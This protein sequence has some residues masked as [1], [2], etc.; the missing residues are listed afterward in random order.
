MC[1]PWWFLAACKILFVFVATGILCQPLHA[2]EKSEKVQEGY[3]ASLET[4]AGE[5]RDKYQ[6]GHASIQLLLQLAEVYLDMG[7]DLYAHNSDRLRAY[8]EGAEFA[9]EALAHDQQNADAHFLYAANLGHVAQL[10]G[11]IEAALSINEIMSHV[12]TAVSLDSSHAGALH[13]LGMMY[14]GL[15]WIMGGDSQKALHFLQL[16]VAVDGN[17]SHARLNLAKL[18]L[19][20]KNHDLARHELE[21]ILATQSPKAR[22]AWSRYHVPEAQELLKGLPQKGISVGANF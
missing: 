20:S 6:R 3:P 21:A 13:M 5:L 17:Y 12:K 14:D 16:A 1:Q 18:Y 7:D 2:S 4:L 10:R 15:P 11:I 22:Y 19:K 8:Q 9:G